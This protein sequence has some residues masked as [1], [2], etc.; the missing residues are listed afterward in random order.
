VLL[1]KGGRDL[2]SLNFYVDDGIVKAKID[3]DNT[4]PD[5]S[6]GEEDRVRTFFEDLL[7]RNFLD[8]EQE[9]NLLAKMIAYYQRT[10]PNKKIA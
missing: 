5:T 3:A 10:Q 7:T 9:K 1:N 8:N 2:L 4:K 6:N